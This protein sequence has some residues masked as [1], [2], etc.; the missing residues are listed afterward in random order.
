MK[1]LY[2]CFAVKKATKHNIIAKTTEIIAKVTYYR[3]N[4]VCG[5]I[6]HPAEYSL[7]FS[8]RIQNSKDKIL[9]VG[10]CNK[11]FTLVRNVC[12][13]VTFH[14]ITATGATFIV[15]ACILFVVSSVTL[16]DGKDV[17][18]ATFYLFP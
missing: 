2:Y 13:L 14:N 7:V 16:N 15:D 18:E 3:F 9:D 10:C 1:G 8:L 5:E 6:S 4:Y 17:L 12:L 11:R